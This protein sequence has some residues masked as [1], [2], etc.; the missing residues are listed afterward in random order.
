MGRLS[1]AEI[2]RYIQE[3][4]SC[5]EVNHQMGQDFLEGRLSNSEAIVHNLTQECRLEDVDTELEK[6]R[7]F[8]TTM[9]RRF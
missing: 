1:A 2:D 7:L 8:A 6:P 4:L 3:A 5:Y 9:G